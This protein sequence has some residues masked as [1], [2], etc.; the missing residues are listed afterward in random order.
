MCL[1]SSTKLLPLLNPTFCLS[2]RRNK[3]LP[4]SGIAIT[5][6]FKASLRSQKTSFLK[7]SP[8]GKELSFFGEF[9]FTPLRLV[10]TGTIPWRV[11]DS[12]S[13]ISMTFNRGFSN[14]KERYFFFIFLSSFQFVLLHCIL[15]QMDNEVQIEKNHYPNSLEQYHIYIK[16]G[17]QILVMKTKD[18][19]QVVLNNRKLDHFRIFGGW[20]PKTNIERQ[21]EL[22]MAT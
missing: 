2:N 1:V 15:L 13:K 12:F 10:S 3:Y 4:G 20:V 6:I 11:S 21:V 9:D 19:L 17:A 5:P 22:Q 16:V 7:Q 14:Q 8:S 18:S